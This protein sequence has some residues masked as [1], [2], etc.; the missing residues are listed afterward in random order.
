MIR[1]FFIAFITL[2]TLV[3]KGQTT[4]WEKLTTEPYAGKQDDIAFIDEQT[5]WYV[6]GYGRIYHTEDGGKT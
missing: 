5:G 1:V 4:H 6:N 2:F 3:L